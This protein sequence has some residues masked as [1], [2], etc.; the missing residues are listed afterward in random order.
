M[1]EP[2]SWYSKVE[3]DQSVSFIMLRDPPSYLATALCAFSFYGPVP[4][5]LNREQ[6]IQ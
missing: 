3:S 2:I 1:R 4:V 6:K 5:I